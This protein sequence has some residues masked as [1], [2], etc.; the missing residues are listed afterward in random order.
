MYYLNLWG[1]NIMLPSVKVFRINRIV[2]DTAELEFWK[3]FVLSHQ[4]I[5]L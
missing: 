3:I 4:L 1:V 2:G 5:I